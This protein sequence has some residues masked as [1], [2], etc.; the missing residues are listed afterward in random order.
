MSQAED[1]A[2]SAGSLTLGELAALNEEIVALVKAGLPLDQGLAR[3]GDD[4]R[5]GLKRIAESLAVRLGRGED[6]HQA[7]EAESAAAPPLYRAVVEAGAKSGNLA[8][9]LEGLA[10]YIRGYAEARETIG[11]ALWYPLV[12]LSLAYL[13]F[14]G[15]VTLVIPRFVEACESLGV[16]V[17]SPVRWLAAV[18]THAWLWWPIWPLALVALFV[19]WRRSGGAA[20]FRGPG[21][22][23]LRFVPW[24]S[25]LSEDYESAGFAELLALLLEH[26]VG[27]P[28]AARLAGEA[29]GNPTLAAG[30]RELAEAVERGESPRAVL[31]DSSP[32][33]FRPLLRWTLAA[34]EEQGSLVKALRNLAPMYR[35]RGAYQAEKLRIVLPTVL[36]VVLGG[37]ATALYGLSLFVPLSTMLRGIAIP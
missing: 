10:R 16:E 22:T 7:L 30:A 3:I 18:G 31:K 24:M 27:Y 4:L 1:G 9:A 5:G 17:V 21:R 35:K 8:S 14:L 2:R 32:G 34:G 13:L 23:V 20:A 6:L 25:E 33:A 15:M 36:M 11:L 28:Q 12:V 37:T 26:G 19:A 29:S